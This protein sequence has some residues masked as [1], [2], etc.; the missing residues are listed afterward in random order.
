MRTATD[1]LFPCHVCCLP[2]GVLG[3]ETAQIGQQVQCCRHYTLGVVPGRRTHTHRHA[4]ASVKV[5]GDGLVCCFTYKNLDKC[6]VPRPQRQLSG[7]YLPLIAIVTLTAMPRF[8]LLGWQMATRSGITMAGWYKQ[9]IT[10]SSS[11]YTFT[12]DICLL[13]WSMIFVRRASWLVYVYDCHPLLPLSLSC[14]M[15][16]FA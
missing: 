10:T 8:T 6:T 4:F 1:L 3:P 7:L 2:V 15:R 11:R 14:F 9:R 5:L 13:R 12:F 16:Y